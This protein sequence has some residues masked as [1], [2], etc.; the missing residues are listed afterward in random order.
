M[1]FLGESG[2]K[3]TELSGIFARTLE[4]ISFTEEKICYKYPLLGVLHKSNISILIE[5]SN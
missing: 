2:I 3:W 1:S 5:L 4:D